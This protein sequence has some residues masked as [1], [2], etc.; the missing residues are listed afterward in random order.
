VKRVITLPLLEMWHKLTPIV[1][2]AAFA[3]P[4]DLMACLLEHR[5]GFGAY[6]ASAPPLKTT[7]DDDL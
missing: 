2:P 7:T 1:N 6:I 3:G 4:A 5:V